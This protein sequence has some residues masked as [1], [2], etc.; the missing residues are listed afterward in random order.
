M[1]AQG[2]VQ[3]M[4]RGAGSGRIAPWGPENHGDFRADRYIP[5]AS[6]WERAAGYAEN[7]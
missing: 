4:T 1:L 2:L 7:V 6:L 5:A 3:R